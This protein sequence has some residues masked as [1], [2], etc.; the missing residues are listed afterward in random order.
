MAELWV[1]Q[2]HLVAIPPL[3]ELLKASLLVKVFASCNLRMLF[4]KIDTK[5]HFLANVCGDEHFL[6]LYSVESASG[7]LLDQLWVDNLALNATAELFRIEDLL[8]AQLNHFFLR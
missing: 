3:L 1:G 4:D 7:A 8:L 5:L 6:S 2:D